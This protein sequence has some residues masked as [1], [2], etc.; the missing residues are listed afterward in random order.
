MIIYTDGSCNPNPGDAAYAIVIKRSIEL[1]DI[2]A[3]YLGKETSNRAEMIAI[4]KAFEFYTE[5]CVEIRCDSRNFDAVIMSDS[6]YCVKGYNQWM[7]K[8]ATHGWK[9]NEDLWTKMYGMAIAF[10]KVKLRFIKGHYNSK[11]N[12]MADKAAGIAREKKHFISFSGRE[13]KILTEMGVEFKCPY[14][15]NDISHLFKD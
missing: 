8:W 2:E 10:P 9:K 3:N 4:L 11:G 5:V 7:H 13:S 14:C 15:K 1:W 12:I 6:Q